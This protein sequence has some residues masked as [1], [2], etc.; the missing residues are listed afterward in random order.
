MSENGR[1][2]V[3]ELLDKEAIRAA[4][5]RY[6]RGVDRADAGLIASAYHPDAVDEHGQARFTGDNV[7][8]GI[9]ELVQSA[10]VSLHQVTNQ[11]IE[12]HG[13]DTAGSE[14]YFTAWQLMESDGEERMLRA[15]GRYVDRMERRDGEWRIAHRKVIVEFTQFLPPATTLPPSGNGRRDRK[16]PSYG[17]LNTEA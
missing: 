2:G 11:Q 7:G 8:P 14:T 15:L 16:D 9:V 10:R 6:C 12:L 1:D 5:L 13:P 4:M 17:V 3:Q